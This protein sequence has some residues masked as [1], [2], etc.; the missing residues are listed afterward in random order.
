V[1]V[2]ADDDHARTALLRTALLVAHDRSE[3]LRGLFNV[4]ANERTGVLVL[5]PAGH[6]AV[7]VAEPLVARDAQ[8]AHHFREFFAPA[9]Q[10]RLGRIDVGRTL[11]VAAVG[12]SHQH[13]AMALGGVLCNRAAAG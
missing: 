12:G 7:F 9:H 10:Q 6:S 5:R 8:D 11:A 2:V 13:H 4:A 3:P 1:P